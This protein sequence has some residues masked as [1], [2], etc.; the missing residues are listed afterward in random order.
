MFTSEQK[1]KPFL[2]EMRKF[3]IWLENTSIDIEEPLADA[4]VLL[5][6]GQDHWGIAYMTFILGK[7]AGVTFNYVAPNK[8][9]PESSVYFLP[10][11]HGDQWFY[12]EYYEDLKQ[13]VFNGATLYISNLN[14]F[15]TEREAFS[16][17]SVLETAEITENGNF[18]FNGC[19]I[20][21][22]V[23]RKQKLEPITASV[24]ASDQN[25]DPILTVN[26]YGKGKVYF[27][28]YPL[29][30]MLISKNNAF[31]GDTYKIYEYVLKDILKTKNV[32]RDNKMVGV[33]ENGNLVT[34]INYSNTP[35]KSGL[36]LQ[37]NKQIDKIYRG[38]PENIPPCDG[39]VF[40]IK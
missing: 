12:K 18:D 11:V 17:S 1:P 24:L 40:S 9:I 7:Q 23:Q 4:T 37:N 30:E 27:I 6:R 28:N 32:V 36:K 31:D 39:V 38:D 13:K 26:N 5:S 25:G 34:L 29:E 14:G 15:F 2:D 21:Y 33:T 8:K 10:S 19:S 16:G 35:Q 3:A 20:P 22:S